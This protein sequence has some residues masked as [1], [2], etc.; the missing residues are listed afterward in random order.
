MI[1]RSLPS[2]FN[3]PQLKGVDKLLKHLSTLDGDLFLSYLPAEVHTLHAGLEKKGHMLTQVAWQ[4]DTTGVQESRLK[5][6]PNFQGIWGSAG[7]TALQASLYSRELPSRVDCISNL[8]LVG[9]LI[10]KVTGQAGFR[11]L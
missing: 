2:A 1:E 3:T 6:W 8:G 7:I 9:G 11:Q 5:F 4:P 10:F